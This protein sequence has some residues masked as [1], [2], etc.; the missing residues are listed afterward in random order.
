MFTMQTTTVLY[1]AGNFG[2][3]YAL[4]ML[5]GNT[6]QKALYWWSMEF[7]A[8]NSLQRIGLTHFHLPQ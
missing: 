1:E 8:L 3:M 7:Y 2:D 6:A 5:R 4:Y